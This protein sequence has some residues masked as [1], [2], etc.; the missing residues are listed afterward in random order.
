[1][2]DIHANERVIAEWLEL[3][4]HGPAA[5]MDDPD[6][7]YAIGP[8]LYFV[9]R[10]NEGHAIPVHW[11]PSTDANLWPGIVEKALDNPELAAMFE[12]RLERQGI[13]T[14][15]DVLDYGP[16]AWTPALAQAIREMKEANDD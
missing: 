12:T 6:V 1:M 10:D 5:G 13:I 4:I 15:L 11:S 16:A 8:R 3:E 2:T 9:K 7:L 14:V